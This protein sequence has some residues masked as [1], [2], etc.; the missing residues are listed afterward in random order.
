MSHRYFLPERKVHLSGILAPYSNVV[1]VVPAQISKEV[2]DYTFSKP[3]LLDEIL[4][5]RLVF[6]T[7]P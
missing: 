7:L 2:L 1:Y 3:Y 4:R 6:P 5:S